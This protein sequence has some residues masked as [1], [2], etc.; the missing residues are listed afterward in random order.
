[1]Q[2]FSFESTF[3]KFLY[4]AFIFRGS[5]ATEQKTIILKYKDLYQYLDENPLQWITAWSLE[6]MGISKCLTWDVLLG[7]HSCS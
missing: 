4:I 7:L 6:H 1:M 2:P 5:K 3:I